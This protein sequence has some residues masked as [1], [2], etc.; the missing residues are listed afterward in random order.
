[1]LKAIKEIGIKRIFKYIFYTLAMIVFR[2]LIF[3]PLRVVFLRLLGARIGKNVYIGNV[4]FYNYHHEYGFKGLTIGNNAYINEEV[5]I[6]LADKITIEDYAVVA[7]RCIILTHMKVSYGDHP[8]TTYL[9][10]FKKPVHIKKYAVVGTGTLIL[11]G[12]TIGEYAAI[13]VGSIVNKDVPDYYGMQGKPI[14]LVRRF[15]D[16]KQ[17]IEHDKKTE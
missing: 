10:N 9:P 17:Q 1:M 11:P 5:L 4:S 12:I 7:Y 3:P 16:L 13:G 8:L 6:D 15:D 2:F 14:R